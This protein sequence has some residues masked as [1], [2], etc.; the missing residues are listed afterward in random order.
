MEHTEG[1]LRI[2]NDAKSRVRQETP[3]EALE[4]LKSHPGAV[5]V[6]VREDEKTLPHPMGTLVPLL[7]YR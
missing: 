6:D 3:A 5:L 4:R 1:F 7:A 2:V